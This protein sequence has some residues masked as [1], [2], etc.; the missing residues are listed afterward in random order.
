MSRSH[1]HR[2]LLES[3]QLLR[4]A[5]AVRSRATPCYESL[6]LAA[7]ARRAG[8]IVIV[9][10]EG[11]SPADA[12]GLGGRKTDTVGE[13]PGSYAALGISRTSLNRLRRAMPCGRA[14][15]PADRR[16]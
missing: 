6:Q 5:Q 15:P 14:G 1:F 12:C 7:A 8:A 2:V 11:Q 10:R 9:A 4:H 3:F 13:S 16:S